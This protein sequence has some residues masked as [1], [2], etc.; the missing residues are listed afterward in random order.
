MMPEIEMLR[1]SQQTPTLKF[2]VNMQLHTLAHIRA[3]EQE[4]RRIKREKKRM[5][6]RKKKKHFMTL[7]KG[8]FDGTE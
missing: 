4:L 7:L 8:G 5:K 1:A 2:M 3:C 6:R